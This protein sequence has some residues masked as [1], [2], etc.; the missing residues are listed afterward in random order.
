MYGPHLWEPL[1]EAGNF[2]RISQPPGPARAFARRIVDIPAILTLCVTTT[3]QSLSRTS[4][5]W[6][7]TPFASLTEEAATHG[8]SP[9][10]SQ[11]AVADCSAPANAARSATACRRACSRCAAPTPPRTTASASARTIRATVLTVPEPSSPQRSPVHLSATARPGT[12][13]RGAVGSSVTA[14]PP[15]RWSSPSSAPRPQPN[16]RRRG[17]GPCR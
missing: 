13:A 17:R 10:S 6:I 15:R 7:P 4:Q 2:L 16:L 1:N 5:D 9:T 3:R 12:A 14:G 11:G 8:R